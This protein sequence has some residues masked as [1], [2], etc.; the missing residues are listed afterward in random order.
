MSAIKVVDYNSAWPRLFEEEKSRIMELI[1]D[2]VDEIHHVGST[3]IVGLCAKPKIDVAWH[4]IR[5][6][7]NLCGSLP[8]RHDAAMGGHANENEMVARPR[9]NS[10]GCRAHK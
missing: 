6:I 9:G 10:S 2:M 4:L 8:V 7:L 5:V 1:S 3:S